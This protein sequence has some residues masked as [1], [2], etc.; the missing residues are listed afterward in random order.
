MAVSFFIRRH[1]I[2][3]RCSLRIIVVKEVKLCVV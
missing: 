3:T 2:D 1:I